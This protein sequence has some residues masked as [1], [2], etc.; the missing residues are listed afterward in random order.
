MKRSKKYKEKVKL[1]DQ[2]KSYSLKEAIK[3]LKKIP[4]S[5]FDETVELSLKLGID[6]K[7]SDQN[8]RGVASLPFGLG[9]KVKVAV[10]GKEEKIKNIQA[11]FKGSEELIEKI[12]KG[13][14][15]FDVLVT[16]PD[17]MPKLR[18]LGKVLGPKGLMPNP[19]TGTISND[20]EK[21]VQVA[22]SGRVEFRSDK[23]GNINVGLGKI[24]FLEDNIKKNLD[25]FIQTLHKH[26]PAKCKKDLILSG[27][28]SLSVSP[29]IKI[30]HKELA[31]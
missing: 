19:K 29:S 9:K 8:I 26:K 11:D 27:T 18:I 3:L 2:N 24:S 17:F 7:Q 10:L 28:I 6:P 4:K 21:A 25:N 14:T 15:D 30:D 20:L 16:S 5:A 13:W 1:I 22:K 23:G 31:E 12:K